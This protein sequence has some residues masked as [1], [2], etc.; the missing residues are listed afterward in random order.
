MPPKGL[1]LEQLQQQGA[2]PV[3][4]G[5]N[6]P[7]V[8][9]ATP[10]PTPSAQGLTVEQ[11][12]NLGAQPVQAATAPSQPAQPPAGPS[13]GGFASNVFSS[14]ADALGNIASAVAHPIDTVEN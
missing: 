11:L 5:Q 14:G 6:L 13:V 3:L 2:T 1:T 8:Q 12:Q 7:M 9:G 10:A 4:P